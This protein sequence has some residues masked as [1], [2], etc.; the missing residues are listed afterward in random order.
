MNIMYIPK[1]TRAIVILLIIVL[2]MAASISGCSLAFKPTEATTTET[3]SET[4]ANTVE[5]TAETT[6][7]ETETALPAD[8]QEI[9]YTNTQ[10]GFSFSLP[11]S[12]EGYSIIISEWEGFAPGGDIP[13]RKVP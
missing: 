6:S 7:I 11:I 12:W 8:K 5:T 1:K 2:L 3:M 4:T 9:T 13:L 10:Y